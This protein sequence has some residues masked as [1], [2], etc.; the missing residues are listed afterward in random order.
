MNSNNRG[1]LRRTRWLIVAV[2]IT[3]VAL[4]LAVTAFSIEV[5][6]D[7][8][9]LLA[10]DYLRTTAVPVAD[11]ASMLRFADESSLSRAFRRLYQTTPRVYRARESRA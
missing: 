10:R 5:L 9:M 6:S 2:F 7:V 4:Q 11:V 3:I 8:R 1:A